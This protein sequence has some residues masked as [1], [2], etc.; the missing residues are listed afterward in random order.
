M[1]CT[2]AAN[3]IRRRAVL[4]A[5]AVGALLPRAGRAGAAAPAPAL[6]LLMVEREGCSYCRRWN[7]EIGPAYP[8]TAEGAAAPLRR[9]QLGDPLPTGVT[10]TGRPPVFTPTFILLRDG[11]ETARIEGYAGD[12]FFWVLLAGMLKQAGWSGPPPQIPPEIPSPIPPAV[13][14]T[15]P[16]PDTE[17]RKEPS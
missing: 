8:H 10:L 2:A 13:P 4:G 6:E 1:P 14:P 7:E 15:D 5:L 11:V 3:S 12:E 16:Q 17:T 9:H